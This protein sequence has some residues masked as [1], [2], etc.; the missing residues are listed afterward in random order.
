MVRT[1]GH[2]LVDLKERSSVVSALQDFKLF[3]VYVD[4]KDTSAQVVIERAIK[5]GIAECQR[6]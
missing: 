6:I 5:E 3:R 1:D 2:K 4:G